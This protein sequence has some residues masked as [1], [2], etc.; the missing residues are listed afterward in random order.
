MN[1]IDFGQPGGYPF[2]QDTLGFL[3][4]AYQE[5]LLAIGKFF[6]DV[7]LTGVNITAGTA[8]DG[9]IIYQGEIIAFVGGTV[10]THFRIVN[11]TTNVTY[12]DGSVKPSINTRHAE[13]C[14]SGVSGAIS[15]ASLLD[16]NTYRNQWIT[17]GLQNA[18]F[19]GTID[20]HQLSID[21]LYTQLTD[22]TAVVATL[23]GEWVTLSGS[24]IQPYLTLNG[25][26]SYTLAS[27]TNR[28]RYRLRGNTVEMN[29]VATIEPTINGTMTEAKF[30]IPLPGGVN[31][32]DH[33]IV[34]RVR[35]S[36]TLTNEIILMDVFR[37]AVYPYALDVSFTAG[38]TIVIHVPTFILK[39]S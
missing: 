18:A 13:F 4:N 3:Q 35:N 14:A 15:F 30:Q 10:N 28:I 11:T 22:L 32:Y 27:G 38:D 8:T 12:Q 25:T 24:A 36:T 1:T 29:A 26:S 20:D 34:G 33:S 19:Q 9:T 31:S 6:G 5:T 17:Q 39:F 23:T 16:L 7:I 37:D 2:E 21:D